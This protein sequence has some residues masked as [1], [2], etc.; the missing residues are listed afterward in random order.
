MR[1]IFHITSKA[2]KT[3]TG[4][5]PL[6]T[7]EVLK[8]IRIVLFLRPTQDKLRLKLL[9]LT[10]VFCWLVTYATSHNNTLYHIHSQTPKRQLQKTDDFWLFE[11]H[12]NVP[13][14]RWGDTTWNQPIAG[15]LKNFFHNCC[16]VIDHV[17]K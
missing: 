16:S 13:V 4:F 15:W 10:V 3:R 1:P 2:L 6:V 17:A 12:E 7:D 11:K 5:L 8:E 9:M 14:K